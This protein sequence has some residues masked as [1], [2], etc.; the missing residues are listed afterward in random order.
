MAFGQ[1][2][3]PEAAQAVQ[4][5]MARRKSGGTVP[6]LSQVSS[7][8]PATQ[9]PPPS[10]VESSATPARPSATPGAKP[11]GMVGEDEKMIIVKAM[12]KRLG[13]ISKTE[14]GGM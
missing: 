5:A 1:G 9:A 3:P 13:D 12:A 14:R 6:Q 10:R 11:P 2:M 8:L 7:E 4:E